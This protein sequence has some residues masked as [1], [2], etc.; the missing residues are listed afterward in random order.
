MSLRGRDCSRRGD[1]MQSNDSLRAGVHDSDPEET[2][3]WLESFEGVVHCAGIER[4]RHI[5]QSLETRARQ[6]GI[7]RPTAAF[8]AYQNTLSLE[9]QTPHPGDV[10]LEER[11]TAI[12]R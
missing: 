8:S 11:I 5:L 4:A 9:Q 2:Q 10:A 7:V 1:L 6:L 3:E 12:I